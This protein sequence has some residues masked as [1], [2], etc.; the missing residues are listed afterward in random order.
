MRFAFKTSP[1]NTE[2]ADMLAVWQA[3]DGI[4]VFESGWTFD[5]FYPIFSDPTGPCLEGW[6]TL[7]ALAQATTRLRIGVMVTGIHYRHPAVLANMASA[8]D[9]VSAGRLEL[10]IGAGWNEEESGAY[11]IE[12]G[13]IRERFDRFEEACQ[14]LLGLL[15]QETTTFD[16]RYYQLTDARNEPKG[17][18]KPHPP[19]CIGGSGEKR[20]LPLTARYANHWNFMGGSPEEFA[21]KRD[22]LAAACADIG[23]DP[24]E[25]TLSAHVRL[26]ADLDYA[27]VV[28]DSLALGAEGLDLAIVYLPTPHTPAVLEPLAEAIRDAG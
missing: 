9:I 11:G 14:V 7:A 15:T 1:Q 17:V 3:A 22:V 8:L 18:Q 4:D 13:S 25:I 12:L 2:W 24:A 28:D 6:V 26:D 5:H 23:R 10:G 16:G 20:T 27:K 19:I 21:R